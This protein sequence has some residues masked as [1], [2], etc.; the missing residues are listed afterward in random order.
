MTI[1]PLVDLAPWYRGDAVGRR[2]VATDVD[3]ALCEVGTLLVT[4]HPLDGAVGGQLRR[5]AAAFFALPAA[6]K[7][8]LATFPGGRGWVPPGV[9]ATGGP[10]A[11]PDLHESFRFGPVEVPAAVAGTAEECWFGPNAWPALL[12]GLPAAARRWSAGVAGLT[13][14]LLRICALALDLAD[15][16]FLG[17]G[18]CWS[19]DLV[20]CPAW[21]AVGSV[22]PGQM[23]VGAHPDPG[24]LTVRDRPPGAGCSQLRTA[25][26]EWTEVPALPGAL[27]VDAGDLLARWT[28]DR[29]CSPVRRVLPPPAESPAEELLVLQFA[30]GADPLAEV[31]TVPTPAAGPSRHPPVTVGDFLRARRDALAAA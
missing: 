22:E 21:S 11:P 25:E 27:T 18:A 23:R 26:G 3:R 29:W 4:G 30:A 6:A 19:A 31:R 1:V 28:G 9:P 20:F 17:P 12:P 16:H 5:Q 7:A 8:R 10:G 2:Q 24:T 13:D 15:D 14:D